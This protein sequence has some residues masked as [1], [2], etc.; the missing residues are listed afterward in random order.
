MGIPDFSSAISLTPCFSGVVGDYGIKLNRFNGFEAAVRERAAK[1]DRCRKPLKRL[2]AVQ[3]PSH[4]PLKQG[5]NERR[6]AQKKL[7]CAGFEASRSSDKETLRKSPR[8]G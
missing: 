2:A 7:R 1:H 8:H 4:T 6:D 3:A 5:V